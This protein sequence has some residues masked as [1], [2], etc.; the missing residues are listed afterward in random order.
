MTGGGTLTI[1][2]SRAE[3]TES[4]LADEPG[5]GRYV[6]IHI[7]DTGSGMPPEVMARVFEPFFTT[8]AGSGGSGLGLSM[9]YGFARQ[10]GG[11]VTVRSTPGAG[12][13]FTLYL[14]LVDGGTANQP[15]AVSRV[16]PEAVTR[17][18]LIVEDDA[19]VRA[20]LTRQVECLGHLA[21][22]VASATEALEI[23]TEPDPP[24]VLVTDVVLGPGMDGIDLALQVRALRPSVP[25]I[26]L[27]GYVA[28]PDAQGR[29]RQLG[30][31]LLAK[32]ITLSQ[33][34]RALHEVCRDGDRAG[35]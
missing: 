3:I 21:F 35:R 5:P 24:D 7:E 25:I 17:S 12:T 2:T 14:P 22:A 28:V 20:T 18:V 32:P 31:P 29:L 8:K 19:A 33:L 30:A 1:R 15:A 9:V 13:C 6:C 26:V 10:S 16:A 34:E 11:A 23:F 4:A 27:S